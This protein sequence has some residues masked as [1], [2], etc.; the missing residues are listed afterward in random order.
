MVIKDF[1]EEKL[2]KKMYA[3]GMSESEIAQKRGVSPITVRNYLEEEMLDRKVQKIQS[4]K[5]AQEWK[6]IGISNTE[7]LK[8]L[9][10]TLKTTKKYLGYSEEEIHKMEEDIQIEKIKIQ[11]KRERQI[12]KWEKSKE[13]EKKREEIKKRTASITELRQKQMNDI[14]ELCNQGIVSVTELSK[15]LNMSI[16]TVHRYKKQLIE[17]DME[18]YKKKFE[19]R[20]IEIK[21][22]EDIENTVLASENVYKNSLW[23]LKVLV[24]FKQFKRAEEFI[25]QQFFNNKLTEEEQIK[26]RQQKD[27]L[28]KILRSYQIKK[29]A[30]IIGNGQKAE[31]LTD[32]E[33]EEE[34][35]I[36]RMQ[37]NSKPT[38][39]DGPSL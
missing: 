30:K 10:L 4:I 26:I 33:T 29:K 35:K 3:D 8:R 31:E 7:I 6:G 22:L 1:E 5:L 18:N 32:L 14:K 21:D 27:K 2:I 37:R 9:N 20:Q 23:F 34:L 11:Q 16:T 36:N 38:K 12:K 13:L 17:M 28:V 25:E 24:T 19:D 15:I 39:S